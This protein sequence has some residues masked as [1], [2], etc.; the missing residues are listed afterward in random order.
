[1]R[2]SRITGP[3]SAPGNGAEFADRIH[4]DS[5]PPIARWPVIN[6]RKKPRLPARAQPLPSDT[7]P[8]IR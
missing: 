8:R 5:R 6:R 7:D 2:E 1:M 4:G 3:P